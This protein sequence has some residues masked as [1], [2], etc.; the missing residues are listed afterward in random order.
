MS[1]K[2]IIVVGGGIFGAT[3]AL[4][5]VTR[6][7]RVSLVDADE[8][9]APSASS[10]DLSKLIRA[11]YGDDS[12]YTK[13]MTKAFEGW[14]TW[15]SKF[16]RPLFHEVGA[17]L[18]TRE[19]MQSGDFEWESY[20]CLKSHGYELRRLE[21]C[22][23]QSEFRAWN[24]QEY[25]DGYYNPVA[26][27]AESGAVTSEVIRWGQEA[28][29]QIHKKGQCLE[30]LKQGDRVCGVRTA[31]GHDLEADEVV[32]CAGAW[33]LK[34]LPELATLLKVVGQPIIYFQPVKKNDFTP[35]SFVPWAAD[36]ARTG[37]YG[38]PTHRGGLLKIANHG[39]GYEIDLAKPLPEVQKETIGEARRF[40]SSSI[41]E[42]K[43]LPVV[44]TRVCLY[45]DSSDGDFLISR[46]PRTNGLT[47]ATAGS[48]HAFKFAPILGELTANAVDG[49]HDDRLLRF[50][51]RD[52]ALA[53]TEQAR[54]TG[55]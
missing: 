9:P 33:S 15:N 26:G 41:P 21:K 52:S 14:R 35:P 54:F 5:L 6:G 7:H 37:W 4:S 10:T 50:R 20:Q 16:E 1:S 31:T 36:I 11:D 38:F 28:G 27:W 19:L 49:I 30:L 42:A 45:C 2:K 3:A 25:T 40:L 39:P 44:G 32:L 23:E 48:G 43:N 12:F 55:D 13:L 47:V 51:W 34:L 22:L 29:V 24:A 8:I 46:H 53:K 17:L 18:L